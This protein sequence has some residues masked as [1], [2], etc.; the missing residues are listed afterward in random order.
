[1]PRCRDS[2]KSSNPLLYWP[3][4]SQSNQNRTLKACAVVLLAAM[5][6]ASVSAQIVGATVSG[7]VT[8]PSGRSVPQAKLVLK[9]LS[10][11]ISRSAL[12][13]ESGFFSAPNLT[14]GEYEVTVAEDSFETQAARLT[15]T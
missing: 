9:S 2:P 1:M 14:P 10:T 6:A 15:L 4:S 13:D 7:V 11:Q 8:D 3:V 12:A 5:N